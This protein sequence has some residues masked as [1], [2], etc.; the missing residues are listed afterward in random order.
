M[1]TDIKA[2]S[3]VLRT[4]SPYVDGALSGDWTEAAERRIELT[5]ADEQELED[6]KLLIKLSYSDSYTHEGGQ[7]L[8]IETRLRLAVRADALEFGG[9]WTRSW[10]RC[11]MDW[12]CRGHS[13]A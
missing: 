7:L 11:R 5:V 9:R 3:L 8:P 10:R 2:H 6:L 13:S 12:T 4:L 1:H